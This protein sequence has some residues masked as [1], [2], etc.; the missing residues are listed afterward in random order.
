MSS[1]VVLGLNILLA[2]DVQS[3]D[4]YLKIENENLFL[5]F[6]RACSALLKLL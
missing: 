5:S 3:A 6:E 2:R 1:D 4:L